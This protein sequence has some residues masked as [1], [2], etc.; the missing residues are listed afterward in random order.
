[1][2][3]AYLRRSGKVRGG[4]ADTM[5]PFR[6]LGPTPAPWAHCGYMLLPYA[7]SVNLLPLH[8]A[9]QDQQLDF[10]NSYFDAYEVSDV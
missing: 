1:M 5:S 2:Q 7:P 4:Q 9:C 8:I 6:K 3:S 10:N